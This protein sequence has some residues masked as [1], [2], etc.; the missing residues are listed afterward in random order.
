MYCSFI[1]F[2]ISGSRK[3]GGGIFFSFPMILKFY[4]ILI[5]NPASIVDRTVITVIPPTTYG[6]FKVSS[7]N[8]FSSGVS[9]TASPT[10][11]QMTTLLGNPRNCSTPM[12]T[13]RS[14]SPTSF[15]VGRTHQTS[16]TPI[17][18]AMNRTI[19]WNAIVPRSLKETFARDGMTEPKTATII[20][21]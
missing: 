5:T 12:P 2:D 19:V 4:S 21:P 16:A 17:R 15:Q 9:P 18:A 7:I 6:T 11:R 14:L 8:A 3:P 20:R 10:S 1:I 13:A